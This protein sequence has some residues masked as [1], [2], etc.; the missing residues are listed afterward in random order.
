VKSKFNGRTYFP[1]SD[2]EFQAVTLTKWT[3]HLL[4]SLQDGPLSQLHD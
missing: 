1:E 4:L 3:I 2:D